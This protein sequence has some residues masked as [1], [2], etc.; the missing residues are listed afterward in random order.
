MK[1]AIVDG[2]LWLFVL[3]QG[4]AVGAGLYEQRL[5]LPLW[6]VPS[7]VGPRVDTDAMRRID[8]GR[9][10]WAFVT[11][12]PLTLLTLVGLFA[13][14]SAEPDTLFVMSDPRAATIGE[15][16]AAGYADRTVKQEL[17]ENLLATL[18]RGGSAFPGLVGFDDSVLPGLERGILAGHDLI[19]LGERGQAKTRL[20]R[21]ISVRGRNHVA[22]GQVAGRADSRRGGK[23][24]FEPLR[25]V[26]AAGVRQ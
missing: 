26:L 2:L 25:P 24:L 1:T 3:N 20:V 18:E 22:E 4:I 8:S 13:V 6:F 14:G 9:R 15:L 12:G 5:V 11:T 21:A 10:F 19:L 23:P 16:R 7:P 17:R